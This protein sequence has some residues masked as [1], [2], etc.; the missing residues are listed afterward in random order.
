RDWGRNLTQDPQENFRRCYMSWN[1]METAPTGR[2][3]RVI[4]QLWRI[5]ATY[6]LVM[7]IHHLEV[8][9]QQWYLRYTWLR[10]DQLTTSQQWSLK[11]LNSGRKQLI[12][13]M[14]H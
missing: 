13:N 2:H 4:F 3:G 14:P 12:L 7:E 9:V 1:L 8:Q 6:V 11:I 10:L 5:V